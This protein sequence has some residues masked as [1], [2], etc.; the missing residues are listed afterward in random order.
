MKKAIAA[1]F[2]IGVW[3]GGTAL[4]QEDA[5]LKRE[6][7]LHQIYE[8][9]NSRPT[10]PDKWNEAVKGASAQKYFVQKGDTLWDIS[11]TFFA[12][13]DFWPKIWSMNGDEIGNPH[14]ISPGDVV[15]LVAGTMG[16][17][18]S[19]GKGDG[20]AEARGS[21]MVS[22]DSS[23]KPKGEIVDV[24]LSQISIPPAKPTAKEGSS[25][26]SSLP[27]WSPRRET[28]FH[29]ELNPVT[30]STGVHEVAILNYIQEGSL[31]SVGRIVEAEGGMDMAHENQY[32]TVAL[33]NAAA[34]QRFL[35]VRPG[36]KIEAANRATGV[37]VHI[38]GEVLVQ[39]SVSADSKLVRA[40]VV[41]AYAPVMKE[42]LLIPGE[43]QRA[44][45]SS[46]GAAG[47]A[48]ARIVG[49]AGGDSRHLFAVGEVIF[50]DGG[51]KSGLAAGQSLQVFRNE[52]ARNPET[53]QSVN[54]RPIGQIS[55]V[56]AGDNFA[57]AVVISEIEE[58]QVGDSTSRG[59][60][61]AS[62]EAPVG[63]SA[64]PPADIE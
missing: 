55:V 59:L 36:A 24:D 1:S 23:K 43:V 38:E 44:S 9:Y 4:A 48:S 39:E 21:E 33:D 14:E 25:V 5:D 49:G 53:S 54:P 46:A 58:M 47:Q 20:S 11:E 17:P 19:L 12:D 30:R 35:V 10:A 45:L 41:K 60:G 32:V 56:R 42:M 62:V 51:A 22:D 50:L 34:G 31:P 40:L 52:K 18:P 8:R 27:P 6:Q 3:S 63:T 64:E 7:R 28:E 15:Q 16:E 26:P 37:Q 13:P 2:L 57:T 29:V 61:A